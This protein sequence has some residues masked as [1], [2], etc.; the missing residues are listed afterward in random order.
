VATVSFG[1]EDQVVE[2]ARSGDLAALDTLLRHIRPFVLRLCGRMLPHPHDAE[3]ACQEVLLLIATNITRF[4]G[5]SAFRTWVRV[6][7]SNGARQTYRKLKRHASEY[8]IDELPATADN[9]TTSVIA[10]TRI[11]LLEA[12]EQLERDR[13]E[14]LEPVVLRELGQVEYTEIADRLNLPIGTVK[15][16]I[17]HARRH[18]RATLAGQP[19]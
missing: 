1:D 13:P 14:L 5:R 11:D 19:G 18:L 17:H 4:E 6:V 15:S 16:Q 7:A 8:P 2:R 9:R 12:L 10:G 3:D